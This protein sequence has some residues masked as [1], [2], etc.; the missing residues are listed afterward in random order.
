MKDSKSIG[1]I[2]CKEEVSVY[3]EMIGSNIEARTEEDKYLIAILPNNLEGKSVLDIACGNGRYSELF[4]KL[5]AKEVIGF[6]LSEEMI[7]EARKRKV[8]NNLK[9]LDLINQILT[10]CLLSRNN[11]I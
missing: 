11:L 8:E 7:V 1:N 6:D 3:Y 2:Y 5:D 4:C 10:R 9:Q